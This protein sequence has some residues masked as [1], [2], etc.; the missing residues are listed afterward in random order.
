MAT[1]LR[2][3]VDPP[4]QAAEAVEAIR[5]FDRQAGWA[6]DLRVDPEALAT[7]VLGRLLGLYH[8]AEELKARLQV[9]ELNR[10]I[11]EA[12]TERLLEKLARAED[13]RDELRSR[14]M[15][16]TGALDSVGLARAEAT[17]LER[18]D[19]SMDVIINGGHSVR[20]RAELDGEKLAPALAEALTE[21]LRSVL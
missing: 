8:A 6:S 5:T 15:R 10:A 19:V 1:T 16:L 20:G 4:D 9:A 14:V 2:S 18:A 13:D 11:L 7:E 12:Q 21:Y 3:R 17:F